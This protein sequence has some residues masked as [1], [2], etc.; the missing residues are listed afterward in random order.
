MSIHQFLA[1]LVCL[2]NTNKIKNMKNLTIYL[3][4]AIIGLF[5]FSCDKSENL[6][7]GKCAQAKLIQH[8]CPDPTNLG[9]IKILS[10][11]NMGIEWTSGQKIYQNVVLA[12]LDSTLLKNGKD[13]SVIIESSDSTFYFTYE[14]EKHPFLVCKICCPPSK[15]II[16]S[17]FSSSPCQVLTDN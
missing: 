15:A 10:D 3:F 17:S 16:I 7:N 9:V 12:Q 5:A 2:K 1:N 13:W 6:S 4:P 11:V 14:L 8:W